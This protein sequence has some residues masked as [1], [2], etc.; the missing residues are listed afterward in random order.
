MDS[1]L[2]FSPFTLCCR[3]RLV[4]FSRPAVMGILN[5]TPDSFYDGGRHKSEADIV[6]H[7]RQMLADGADI[8]DIGV[9]STRPGAQLLEPA[10]ESRRLAPI[11]RLLRQELTPDTLL[12]VDT[13]YSLP[14]EAAVRA[15]ADIVNDVSGFQ[16][17]DRMPEVVAELQ[18][19]YILMHTR[20]TPATMQQPQNTAYSDLVG[21]MALYFSSRLD[22]LRRCGVKDVILDPGFGFAKTVEGNYQALLGL[23]RLC[24][25]FPDTPILAALS[26]KSMISRRLGIPGPQLPRDRE[27]LELGTLALNTVALARG[28]RLLRVHT[29]R[30]SRIAIDL[31]FPNTETI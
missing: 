9:V 26:N 10:E 24:R 11:V 25:L 29:P 3:G 15:G 13:C 23:D 2:H 8:I 16:F 17:D 19:P 21:E 4:D 6:E 7:A 30:L 22:R 28:A 18:T 31:L 14:A 5:V 1:F 27:S 20:G 12:S